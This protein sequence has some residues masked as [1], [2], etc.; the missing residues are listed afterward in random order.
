MGRRFAWPH[1]L[2]ATVLVTAVGQA[3]AQWGRPIGSVTAPESAGAP[4]R[5]TEPASNAPVPQWGTP[6][7]G[8]TPAGKPVAGSTPTTPAPL[9]LTDSGIA[10]KM[11]RS[12]QPPPTGEAAKL[13]PIAVQGQ[14]LR[15]RPD[16]DA[17]VEGDARL[18]RGNLSITT[19]RLTY[20]QAE[21]LAVARG[22]VN[23]TQDKNRYSGPEVQLKTQ[24][25]EGYFLN[26]TYF[27][28]R[29]QAGGTADRIDFIGP[30]HSVATNATYSSCPADGSGDPAW[31]LSSEQI[32]TDFDT[33]TGVAKGA[34]LRFLGVPILWA[35]E[36]SFP[37][38][39]ERKSGW[40]PPSVAIDSNAGV[41]VE[42]PWYWNIAPNRDATL[43]PSASLRRGVGLD[44]EFRY[45]E[46][47]YKGQFNFNFLPD[48]NVAKR[49]RYSLGV[50]HDVDFSEAT[51]LSVNIK[52]V[53]DDDYWKDFQREPGTVTPRLLLSD[54]QASHEMGDWTTYAR[55]QRW[56]VLQDPE[57][58]IITPYQ[59]LPQ[60]GVRTLQTVGNGFDVSFEG[61]Y[62]RFTNPGS[63]IEA[64]RLDG[65]RVHTLTSISYPWVTT[66]GWTLTPKVALNAAA[67]SLSRA[68][69]TGG[70]RKSSR[71]IPT[72]S[73]D[74]AWVLERET[75]W[76]GTD[77]LQTLEPRVLYVYTPY[78]KQSDFPIFDSA[79]RDLN[80]ETAFSE[81]AFSGIDRVS[82]SNQ[83]IAGAKTRLINPQTGAE[84]MRLGAVQ[85]YLLS[86]Q[87]ITPLG[88]PQTRRVSD[89]LLLGSTSVIPHWTLGTTLQYN[90]EVNALI[91]STSGVTYSPGPFRT[92]SLIYRQVRGA[93][94]Q[95]ET[96]WQWPIYGRT[97][98]LSGQADDGRGNL[99]TCTGS[100]YTVGRI[101]YSTRDSRLVDGI[102]GFEY[103][104]GCWIARVV[105]ERLSTGSSNA[106]T[107]LLFQIEFVGLSR[108]GSNPLQVLKDNVPGYRLLRD[109]PQATQSSNLL[110][111]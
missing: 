40:L 76:F 93:S 17:V 64:H 100:L 53:S 71:V 58:Q 99:G 90:P 16:L 9:A 63:T 5:N 38:T 81:N 55:V 42:A 75:N 7:R 69:A 39:N 87:R 101:N 49:S 66:P 70:D 80:F 103:D 92:V 13:L 72:V 52:R 106:T 98:D 37:L 82:D 104:A 21:D 36:L 95:V 35:P 109:G 14:S 60:I 24:R 30:Q 41:R 88:T 102:M 85:R 84:V 31:L 83:V 65:D 73:L 77:L 43:T 19:D 46:P 44:T 111:E 23:I 27:F 25:F 74:S 108:L 51:R 67:Y 28:G 32:D 91:T 26:P 54:I 48:D 6:L 2:W 96:G 68:Y 57:A 78:R 18:R 61:E 50:L 11:A 59:R 15:G 10:L 79:A 94:Q 34:V 1:A 89:L 105:A 47:T 8:L 12:L 62:N 97:P 4:A 86:D 110:Y 22:N 45:L 29:T 3:C 33:N 56:Q 107:R 20:D